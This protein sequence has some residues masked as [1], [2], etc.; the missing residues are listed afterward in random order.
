MSETVE[1]IKILNAKLDSLKAKLIPV[2]KTKPIGILMEVYNAGFKVFG[3]NYVQELLEKYENMPKDISWHMIGHLQSNKV[4]YIAPFVSLIHSVDS[5]K[6][7]VEINKQA[8][9]NNRVIDCLLQV[10]IASEDSKSGF[11]I[12]A[13]LDYVT[14]GKIESLK[15]V[16]IKGLMGMSTFTDNKSIV[17][18]EFKELK[19]L[20][21]ELKKKNANVNVQFEELSMGMSDDWELAVEQGSTMVRIGSKIFG[22]RIYSL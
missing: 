22:N 1:N 16:N 13:I 3:E 4:K 2:S 9:K 15:N 20:F 14:S 17:A 12:N 11:D 19:T 7:L 5:E 18:Q 6:L 8:I 21:E 10:H